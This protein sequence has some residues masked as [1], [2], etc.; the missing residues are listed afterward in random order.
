[1]INLKR[2]ALSPNFRQPFIIHRKV[3]EWQ[4]GRFVQTELDPIT[5]MGVVTNANP[6]ELIQIPEGDRVAGM[7]VF[8]CPKELYITHNYQYEDTNASGT[9]DE[10]EWKGDRYKILTTFDYGYQGFYKAFA[11]YMEGD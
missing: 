7:M 3:G 11:V 5:V 1:M 6:K 2:V 4:S 9:S 8:Y 10:L